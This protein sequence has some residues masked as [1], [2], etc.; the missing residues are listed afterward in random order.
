MKTELTTDIYKAAYI[1]REGGVVAI[2]TETVYGL[3]AN[4]LNESAVT[5]IYESKGRPHFNP[6]IIHISDAGRLNDLV[7]EIPIKASE[8]AK[9]F[10]PGPLTLVLKKQNHIPDI[11]TAGKSTVAVRVPDHNVTRDLLYLLD[12]PLAAPSA[13]MFGQIS[14]S[15]TSHVVHG[16]NGRIPLVLEGGSCQ[17]GIES[18][19]VSFDEDGTPV[20]LRPGSITI[21]QI[22]ECVGPVRVRTKDNVAPDAPGML[23]RHYSPRTP[24][25][26]ASDLGELIREFEGKKIG[27]LSLT[28]ISRIPSG[29]VQLCLSDS[30]DLNEAAQNLY[31]YMHELDDMKLDVLLFQTMPETGIGISINDR[32]KRAAKGH[33]IKQ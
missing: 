5:K 32:L 3:A 31:R 9:R 2:P 12:F 17:K 16:L 30:G 1:L 33:E 18:T 28:G 22:E 13:N 19:I 24:A 21:E 26:L 15:E 8:L 29:A 6:L 4:A 11:V 10:W 14:P 7:K 27:I 25:F 20:L 23:D